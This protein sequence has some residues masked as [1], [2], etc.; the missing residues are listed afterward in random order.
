MSLH[1]D[2]QP[3]PPAPT[4]LVDAT[5]ADGRRV[6]VFLGDGRITAV[7]D[8]R[9]DPQDSRAGHDAGA[10]RLDGALLLPALVDGHAH[11]DKTLLGAPWQPHRATAT[12]REQIANE[13]ALRKE[14]GIPVAERATALAER[15]VTLGT[16]HVRSHVDIDLDV[17][18]DGLHQLLGVREQF[19]D[20]LGIQLVAFPQSGVVTAPGVADLL[21]AALAE[22]ADL[23]GGLDPAGF[24]GDVDGQLDIVFG[25]A[26]RHGTGIDIHLHDGGETGTFQLRAVAERTAALGLE[27]AVTVSHAYAL[28]DVDTAELDRTAAALAAAGVAIMTNGPRHSMPPVLRLRDHGVRVF[29]GSDNIRDS[30]WPYGTADMLERATIIGLQGGLMTDDELRYAASLATDEAAAA[31]GLSDY[32][33][34]PGNRADLVVIA[35]G[36]VPE[37]VA[38]HPQRLLV[39]HGGRIVGPATHPAFPAG[40]SPDLRGER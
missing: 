39:L 29:A 31:L 1:A 35:A 30:W 18:L 10:V 37:A 28:G 8:H 14:T 7:E 15:M 26:E 36:G 23:I 16:G 32:G 24:D 2:T 11:L 33:L 27:G 21:D 34:A 38:A 22:G 25:L 9:A 17:R 4:V 12:L 40:G 13:R 19:R 6:D 20:R 3:A 5:L